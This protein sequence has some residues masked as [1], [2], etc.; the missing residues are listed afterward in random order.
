MSRVI[1][2]LTVLLVLAV[3]SPAQAQQSTSSHPTARTKPGPIT[4]RG[5]CAV[6][7]WK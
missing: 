7:F 6:D 3:P 2:L 1:C 5:G 4:L